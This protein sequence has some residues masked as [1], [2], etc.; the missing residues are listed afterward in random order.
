MKT[1]LLACPNEWKKIRLLLTALLK[2]KLISSAKVLN[3]AKDYRLSPDG[4]II[5]TE[6]KLILIT[7]EGEKSEIFNL[8]NKI[9]SNFPIEELTSFPS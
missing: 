4:K 8:M 2:K 7:Y 1:L 3:Y 6:Q 9:D 5:K